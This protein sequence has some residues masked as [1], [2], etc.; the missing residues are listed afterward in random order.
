M[1]FCID[2]LNHQN[3]IEEL[4]TPSMFEGIDAHDY[5]LHQ[6][7]TVAELNITGHMMIY[8]MYQPPI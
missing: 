2:R 7:D 5:L 6:D 1:D 8:W 4:E 3:P